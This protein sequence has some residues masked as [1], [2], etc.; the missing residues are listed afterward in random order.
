[1]PR[2]CTICTHPDREGIDKALLD[3]GPYRGIAERFGASPSAVYR[4]K[5][6]H[7]P[8]ALVRAVEA[9]EVAHGGDLLDQV[10]AAGTKGFSQS[11]QLEHLYTLGIAIVER[12]EKIQRALNK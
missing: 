4:H 6:D 12:L 3:G 9:R 1:M 5:Q 8:K 2:I 11:A 10:K 7:L